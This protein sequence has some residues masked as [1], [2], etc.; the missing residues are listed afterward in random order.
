VTGAHIT[1]AEIAHLPTVSVPQAGTLLGIGRDASYE[2]VKRGQIPTL[3]LGRSLRVPVPKL[4][5]M[6]GITP[7]TNE[8]PQLQEPERFTLIKPVDATPT[9]A[10]GDYD[11]HPPAA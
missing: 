2:A 6:L 8:A 1:I 3:T 9:F 7:E 11:T 5:A 10:P 4:L